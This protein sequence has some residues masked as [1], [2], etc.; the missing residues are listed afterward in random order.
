MSSDE[1]IAGTLRDY[2][3][4]TLPEAARQP[5]EERLLTDRPFLEELIAAEDELIDEHLAGALSPAETQNFTNHFLNTDER[6][7]KLQFARAFRRYVAAHAPAEA[8]EP[9]TEPAP[10]LV[11]PPV[12]PP[13]P[14]GWSLRALFSRRNPGFAF[15][16]V[17]ALLLVVAGVTW[18][19][20]LR[21]HA[22]GRVVAVYLTP[23]LVRDA[24]NGAQLAL[25]PGTDAAELRLELPRADYAAYKADLQTPE[26]RT[27]QTA[28]GLK[29]ATVEGRR[30]VALQVPGELLP[31]GDY[32]LRL[33]GTDASGNTEV[34]GRYY[35]RV[36]N[37]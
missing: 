33:S 34:A 10:V 35:F 24:G 28:A 7:N 23:G 8:V 36:I 11:L 21:P 37:R 29:P 9:E 20:A 22:S 4:G 26:G 16:F 13:D 25:V 31:A 5:V 1:N 27:V 2:L 18:V 30:V 6:R 19:A 32:Q 3:L 12:P 15:A 14:G 17:A